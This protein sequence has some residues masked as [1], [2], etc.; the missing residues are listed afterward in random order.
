MAT[1]AAAGRVTGPCAPAAGACSIGRHALHPQTHP[2]TPGLASLNLFG[3]AAMWLLVAGM[4]AV[5]IGL[6]VGRPRHRLL[7]AL[8]FQPRQRRRR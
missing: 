2:M 7:R 3:L 1:A 5:G 8:G 6:A 4:V